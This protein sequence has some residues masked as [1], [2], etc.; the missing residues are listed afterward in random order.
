MRQIEEVLA[1][2]TVNERIAFYRQL[3]TDNENATGWFGAAVANRAR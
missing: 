2:K 1:G 3:I